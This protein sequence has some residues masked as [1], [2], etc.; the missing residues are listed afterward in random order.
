MLQ[1][2]PYKTKRPEIIIIIIIIIIKIP[3]VSQD[4]RGWGGYQVLKGFIRE[5]T[6][7]LGRLLEKGIFE[8]GLE[9]ISIGRD[10]VRGEWALQ[11]ERNVSRQ[12]N[13]AHI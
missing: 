8:L 12:E 3:R 9:V 5:K 6:H 7:W 11:E 4:K 1:M 10:E 2:W 13:R